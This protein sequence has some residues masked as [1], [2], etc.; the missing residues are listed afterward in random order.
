MK[1]L[2]K[3]K[4]STDFPATGDKPNFLS[5]EYGGIPAT[6]IIHGGVHER[7]FTESE[8]REM[9]ATIRKT[10]YDEYGAMVFSDHDY[11][12]AVHEILS[13]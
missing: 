11:D 13:K 8:L 12:V 6:L 10:M 2:A 3:I 7:V 5:D 1:P 4:G 9:F